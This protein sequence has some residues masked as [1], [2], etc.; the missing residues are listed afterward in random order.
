MKLDIFPYKVQA[1]IR[2]LPEELT[3]LQQLWK[4]AGS[5]TIQMSD[6]WAAAKVQ[7]KWLE[8]IEWHLEKVQILEISFNGKLQLSSKGNG[9]VKL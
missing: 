7:T 9:Q 1:R 4:H 8:T 6:P 3:L 5:Q 2:L